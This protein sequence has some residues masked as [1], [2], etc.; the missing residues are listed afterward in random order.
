MGI[1]RLSSQGNS[2]HPL[3]WFADT[4]LLIHAFSVPSLR[5]LRS[6]RS[7]AATHCTHC[8]LPK[9]LSS[10]SRLLNVIKEGLTNPAGLSKFLISVPSTRE[11]VVRYPQSRKVDD[12]A[13][14]LCVQALD[15]YS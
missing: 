10:F 11:Y 2:S 8:H 5:F 14:S 3:F 7:V 12:A 1:G 15:S 6:L 4:G 9:D 13:T